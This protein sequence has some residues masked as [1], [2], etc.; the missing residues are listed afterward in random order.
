LHISLKN[1]IEYSNELMSGVGKGQRPRSGHWTELSPDGHT[2][3]W[4]FERTEGSE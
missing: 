2:W 3:S 1:L 4:R